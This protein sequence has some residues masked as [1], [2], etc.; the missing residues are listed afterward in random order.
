MDLRRWVSGTP[1][2]ILVIGLV[3]SGG[4]A[5]AWAENLDQEAEARFGAQTQQ[6][7]GHLERSF[8][9]HLAVMT[10][11]ASM[12]EASGPIDQTSFQ[13]FTQAQEVGLAQPALQGF[14]LVTEVPADRRQAFEEMMEDS[15]HD[16]YTLPSEPTEG[17]YHAVTYAHGHHAPDPGTDLATQ[18]SRR[19]A[20][21]QADELDGA[22]MAPASGTDGRTRAF[23]V[24]LP[25]TV[26][27]GDGSQPRFHGWVGAY[28]DGRTLVQDALQNAVYQTQVDVYASSLPSQGTFVT[29]LPAATGDTQT[30]EASHQNQHQVA[31]AGSVW[32]IESK[33]LPGFVTLQEELQPW[34]ILG[35]GML[36]TV[37]ISMIGEVV[38]RSEGMAQR[39]VEEATR[40]LEREKATTELLHDI[41]ASANAAQSLE[42]AFSAALDDLCEHT[43]W[44]VGHVYKT[45][46]VED[47]PWSV[48]L[49]ST[50]LWHLDDPERFRDFKAVSDVTRFGP[51]EG[52]PGKVMVRGEPVWS[53][54]LTK[55]NGFLRHRFVG[56]LELGTALAFPVL[57]GTQVVAVLEFFSTEGLGP[58]EDLL[59][60]MVAV[61]NQLGRVVERVR[62]QKEVR[63]AKRRAEQAAKARSE[64][65]SNMSHEIRTPMNAVIG[66][67][68]LL[69]DSELTP[70]Q[71]ES[72]RT[73]RKSGEHLL[74]IINDILDLSKIEAGKLKLE[75]HTFSLREVVED[76]L[77]LVAPRIG[78][79]PIDLA[80][81]LEEGV[82]EALRGD[83]G[84]LRQILLNLTSNAVKFTEEGEVV[85]TVEQLAGDTTPGAMVELAFH[86]RDT[87]I[88]IPKAKQDQLF[89]AFT[90]ADA[91]TTRRFG[92]TG[93][94]LAICQ[95]L[96][97]MM[98]GEI[99]VESTEGE[100]STFSFTIRA[101][102]AEPPETPPDE[103]GKGAFEGCRVAVVDDN[104]TNRDILIH[105]LTAWG[106]ETETFAHPGKA[107]EAIPRAE[108][109]DLL[110]LDHRM[111]GMDGLD[112][113]EALAV[114]LG[115][116]TPP[117]V[118]LSSLAVGRKEAE[119]RGISLAASLSKPVK[120]SILYDTLASTLAGADR[121]VTVEDRD[122]AT[123][124]LA[125]EHPLRILLAEDNHVN[126]K[127][128]TRMLE[129]LGYRPDVVANGH[130]VMDAL[131]SRRY[132]IVLMDV[133]MPEMDGYEAAQAIRAGIPEVQQPRIVAMTAHA[134]SEAQNASLE[135]AMDDHITKPV[136]L[137]QL[138]D[139]LSQVPPPSR[140]GEPSDPADQTDADGGSGEQDGPL[141]LPGAGEPTEPLVDQDHLDKLIEILG[142]DRAEVADLVETFHEEAPG[143][144][145]AMDQ[146]LETGDTDKLRQAAHAL[147]GTSGTLGARRLQALC[148]ALEE[149]AREGTLDQAP[150]EV[151]EVHAVFDRT[152]QALDE[153]TA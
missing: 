77:D 15:G 134:G 51:G 129:R 93:L 29:G 73:I 38:V 133:Q 31:L 70:E 138:A 26:G 24:Y 90:Q 8:E 27:F 42:E 103:L 81:R 83:A 116:R 107:L 64:F 22:N 37:L 2:A 108:G 142:G 99:T 127:V 144:L 6:Y 78:G 147:K 131:V 41:A 84:R 126:Q 23:D 104:K 17:V 1:W 13:R 109:Y 91:S 89:D 48:E 97:E 146:A 111:P 137:D 74:T 80:Y 121:E 100:G 71:R 14:Y 57:V 113:A 136:T 56:E 55:E 92:G 59:A 50:G 65:L 54:E 119:K 40:A 124:A 3:L 75:E 35:A 128:A 58:D 72:V 148:K 153:A 125:E 36:V 21:V 30:G 130:E 149:H 7:P 140:S 43:G 10:G 88:G 152:R 122:Q 5:Y 120:P 151:A 49:A 16:S 44:P 145:D 39:R 34:G 60:T 52:L 87:G 46:H 19:E 69:D 98:D 135:A 105:H 86:V 139:V 143:Y 33:A 96:A 115:D 18:P 20:M 68:G 123:G 94:G 4:I 53:Q 76:S 82:P 25:I 63:D 102:V 141:D 67:A 79:T 62:A 118:M 112:L 12:T 117:I 28:L 85:I 11:M 106:F 61:G 47:G 95:R 101:E 32:T 9:E 114:E 45:E 150:E 66:M 132:D 110:I